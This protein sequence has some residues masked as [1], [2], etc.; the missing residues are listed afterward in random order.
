L[1]RVAQGEECTRSISESLIVVSTKGGL[2]RGRTRCDLE[3][4]ARR[5]NGRGSALEN[6]HWSNAASEC[7]FVLS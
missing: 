5:V 3:C 2:S 6:E 7:L 1:A 4:S